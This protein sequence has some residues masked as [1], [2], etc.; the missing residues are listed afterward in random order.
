MSDIKLPFKPKIFLIFELFLNIKFGSSGEYVISDKNNNIDE[1]TKNKPNNWTSFF[2]KKSNALFIL[3]L[4]FIF[5]DSE[6]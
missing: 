6:F 2:I 3:T 1:M 5:F 4:I